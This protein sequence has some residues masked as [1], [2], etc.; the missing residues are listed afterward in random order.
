MASG[1]DITDTRNSVA[2]SILVEL[3]HDGKLTQAK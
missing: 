1:E 3:E 2:Y